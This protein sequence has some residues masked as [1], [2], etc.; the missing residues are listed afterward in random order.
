[1]Q[2]SL[3]HILLNA[4]GTGKARKARALNDGRRGCPVG[5][6]LLEVINVC[7]WPEAAPGFPN[8]AGE[9]RREVPRKEGAGGS[10]HVPCGEAHPA[11]E[12]SAEERPLPWAAKTFATVRALTGDSSW[13]A[14]FS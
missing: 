11:Q 8:Y 9:K 3:V 12:N 2:S 5:C 1:M 6:L 13:A 10:F 7:E 14:L 4:A